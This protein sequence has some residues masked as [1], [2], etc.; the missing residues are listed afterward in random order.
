MEGASSRKKVK[1]LNPQL[2]VTQLDFP[3][4]QLQKCSPVIGRIMKLRFEESKIRN[5]IKNIH[6]FDQGADTQGV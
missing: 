5:M 4:R 6:S 1:D 3:S 2:C